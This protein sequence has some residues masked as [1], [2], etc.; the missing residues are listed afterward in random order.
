MIFLIAYSGRIW[1]QSSGRQVVSLL[2]FA[3]VVIGLAVWDNSAASWLNASDSL[4]SVGLGVTLFVLIIRH[5]LDINLALSLL[6]VY[7]IGY[8]FLRNWLFAAHMQV[9]SLQMAPMYEVYLQR[10]PNLKITRE[11]IAALQTMIM[12]Y[13]PAIFGSIQISGIYFGLLLFNNSSTLKHPVRFNRLPF[14]IVYPLIMSAAMYLYPAT[15]IFGLNLLICLGMVYLI[16][17]TAVLSF[18]WGDFFARA[19]L[20]RVLLILAIMLN[21]PILILIAFIGV[22]DI[23]FDFRKLTIK[24]IK[25]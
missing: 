21:Y 19:K 5:R 9:I 24:E 22:L 2:F 18:F 4:V 15:K 12:T 7:T 14:V 17:G 16:Q 11:M 1:H 8:T 23:W 13:Q 20:L 25:T 3:A 6:L 10:F